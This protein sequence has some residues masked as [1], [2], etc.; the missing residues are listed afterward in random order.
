MKKTLLL[1]LT[2][3]LLTTTLNGATKTKLKKRIAKKPRQNIYRN[4]YGVM[5]GSVSL[6]RTVTIKS[7]ES[8]A[9]ICTADTETCNE[10]A[11]GF[12]GIADGRSYT[13][14]EDTN[15]GSMEAVYGIQKGFTGNFY[16]VGLFSSSEISGISLSMGYTFPDFTFSKGWFIPFAKVGVG[17][18]Y[19]GADSLNPTSLSYSL[20]VG[21]Y[22]ILRRFK[23][24][25]GF[26][27]AM[28]E[29]SPV[30]HEYGD[31]VWEDK[32]T[33][34]YLGLTYNY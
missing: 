18:G 30:K 15:Y 5:Y 22:T 13:L 33:K 24:R 1:F 21:G 16:E 12:I 10:S 9:K 25:Y 29:W 7:N 28:R 6:K 17:L 3:T 2:L 27:Y 4:Y 23:L 26:D 14:N 34:I 31:E 19:N 20:G 32:E 8:Q 11:E